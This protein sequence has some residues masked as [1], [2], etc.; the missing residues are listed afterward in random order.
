MSQSSE[1]ARAALLTSVIIFGTIGVFRRF[2]PVPS[3]FLAM[4][5]GLLGASSLLL[6]LRIRGG[7]LSREAIRSNGVI[8]LLSGAAIGFN[9]ILLFEAYRYTTVAVATL[10]YYMAPILV[11]LLSPLLLGERMTPRKLACAATA[12]AGMVLVSGVFHSDGA[13]A[14]GMRGILLGLG[15][16]VLY[17]SVILLN[18]KL[19]DL[20]AYDRSVVQL[21][22]AGV[23]LIPY[24]IVAESGEPLQWSLSGV[25]L[26]LLLGVVHTGL[27][28]ALYF[29]SI[30]ALPAQSV[31]LFSYLDPAVAIL[32]SASV[33]K[34]HITTPELFGAALIL[35]AAVVSELPE[36]SE[37]HS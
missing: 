1:K 36:R 5:R 2:L 32:L 4:T 30:A 16:A 6:L 33:L 12:C 23:V 14:S 21:F 26:L 25:C 7:T 9:W 18:K 29:A 10:C 28:Y 34:E 11:L 3:G 17:A 22:V 31:A 27:A 8:L 35:I 13:L 19:V 37:K 24:V 20:P 15:A